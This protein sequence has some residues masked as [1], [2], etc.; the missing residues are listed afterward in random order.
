[1]FVPGCVYC[2]ISV[3]WIRTQKCKFKIENLKMM[4]YKTDQA[5]ISFCF[6]EEYSHYKNYTAADQKGIKIIFSQFP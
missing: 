6:I 2:T 3:F 1:M 4:Q 5:S